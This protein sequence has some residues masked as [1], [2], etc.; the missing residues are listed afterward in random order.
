VSQVPWIII[1]IVGL[2]GLGGL[3]D[4]DLNLSRGP[5]LQLNTHIMHHAAS[6]SESAMVMEVYL[7]GRHKFIMLRLNYWSLQ[8]DKTQ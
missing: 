1:L 8:S 3:A 4:R 7:L 2:G 6:H 5:H